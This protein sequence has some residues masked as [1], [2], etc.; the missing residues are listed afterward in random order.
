MIKKCKHKN[1]GQKYIHTKKYDEPILVNFTYCT[2]CGEVF[3]GSVSFVKPIILPE[4]Q[5]QI[6]N[7]LP[8]KKSQNIQTKSKS[9]ISR[10]VAIKAARNSK[11]KSKKKK[12][13]EKVINPHLS[14][15]DAELR[16]NSRKPS[17]ISAPKGSNLADILRAKYEIKETPKTN[18]QV[19]KTTNKK[20]YRTIDP[21]KADSDEGGDP[22]VFLK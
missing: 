8:T 18:Q 4:P 3:K 2:D 19:I 10:G 9:S 16:K 14:R 15:G 7:T 13:K 17:A 11:S 6:I 20:K 21:Y 5:P 12:S 22:E 1:I